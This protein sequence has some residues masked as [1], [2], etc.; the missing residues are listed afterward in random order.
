MFARNDEQ[1]NGS[2][3]TDVLERHAHFIL[4]N[5]LRGRLV[6][7]NLTEQAFVFFHSG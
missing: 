7:R 3:G 2:F 4:V 1:V 5:Y 6:R